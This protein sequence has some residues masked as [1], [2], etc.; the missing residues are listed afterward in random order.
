MHKQARLINRFEI[1]LP[2]EI[3]SKTLVEKYDYLNRIYRL[4][5]HHILLNNI[6]VF[7][8]YPRPSVPWD[9]SEAQKIAIYD[10]EVSNVLNWINANIVI[11]LSKIDYRTKDVLVRI[12]TG[13]LN[14]CNLPKSINIMFH[15]NMVENLQIELHEV[16]LSGLPF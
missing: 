8:P 3:R 2:K 14:K 1:F 5:K 16:S 10:P 7:G 4:G 9:I 6:D 12:A 11:N 13:M 15:D